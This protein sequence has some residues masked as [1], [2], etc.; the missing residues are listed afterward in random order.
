M[1]SASWMTR[2][3]SSATYGRPTLIPPKNRHPRMVD[4]LVL[5]RVVDRMIVTL[6]I[7]K[8]SRCGSIAILYDCY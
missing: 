3:N 7:R 1:E 5:I 6:K 8:E 2:R 4:L